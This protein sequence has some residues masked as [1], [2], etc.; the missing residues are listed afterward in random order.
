MVRFFPRFFY[1]TKCCVFLLT[2]KDKLHLISVE[3]TAVIE[4]E[5]KR[6]QQ[7]EIRRQRP[8][9]RIKRPTMESILKINYYFI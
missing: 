2:F 9:E 4:Q 5:R 3:N 8:K 1:D 7:K 6:E